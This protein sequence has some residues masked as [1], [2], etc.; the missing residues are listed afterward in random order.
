VKPLAPFLLILAATLAA[1]PPPNPLEPELLTITNGTLTLGIEK[2]MGASITH[3]TWKSLDQKN[4]VNIHD[5]GR[6]IQ[7]SYYAGK[8]LD[9]LKDGQ[10]KAWSPWS[11]NPIQGGGVGSW[12]KVTRFEKQKDNTLLFSETT[13]KLWDMHDEEAQAVMHQWTTFEPGFTNVAVIKNRIIC[14]RDL[15]DPWGPAALNPQEVPA[16]YLTRNFDTFKTY[17]GEGKWR[18]ETQPPGPPWGRTTS[19]RHA[20]ACFEKS[21]Q[22]VAI[23]SP[24]ATSWNFGPHGQ[25]SST[26][27]TAGPCTHFAPVARVNLGPKST[28]TYRYWLIVGTEK[29]ITTSLDLL[30]KKYA[31]ERFSL[32]NPKK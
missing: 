10:H 9:R 3:L 14:N 23:F 17:L 30:W 8:R 12:A 5:P 16:C 19:P 24:S 15:N 27:P 4:I 31:T 18:L 25:G 26:D 2:S 1:K 29:E 13:P 21:G 28:L 6:L 32:T 20:M 11:W 7:Q 22:G